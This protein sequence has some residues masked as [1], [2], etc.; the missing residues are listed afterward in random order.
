M[1][2]YLA[3]EGVARRTGNRFDKIEPVDEE[4]LSAGRERALTKLNS[5]L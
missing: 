4:E 3:A 1:K 2:G 5:R